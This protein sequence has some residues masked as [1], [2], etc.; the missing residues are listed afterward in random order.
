MKIA[1]M[2]AMLALVISLC[3]TSVSAQVVEPPLPQ[4][5]VTAAINQLITL[6]KQDYLHQEKAEKAAEALTVALNRGE[7]NG[8][9]PYGRLKIKLESILS[10]ATGDSSFE[11]QWHSGLSGE[12]LVAE[13]NFPGAIQTRILQNGVGFLAIDGD[14][15][16]QRWQTELDVAMAG[17]TDVTALVIDLRSAGLT[18]LSLAQHFLGYFVPRGQLLAEAIFAHQQ[19][20]DLLSPGT[21]V[22]LKPGTAVYIVLSPFVAGGWEFAAYT[23]KHGNRATIVGMPSIGLGYMMTSKPLSEHLSIG[24]AYATIINPATRDNWQGEGVIP[25]VRCQANEAVAATMDMINNDAPAD[26]IA[27]DE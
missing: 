26:C 25:D 20:S 4:K 27:P 16:D 5:E 2:L 18:S 8:H 1:T 11:L 7:F 17:L 19:R 15:I 23:L 3:G 12:A 24:M 22:P 9:F 13:E 10:A 14:L 6:I 21:S